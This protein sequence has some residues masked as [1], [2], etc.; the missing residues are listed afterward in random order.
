MGYGAIDG[1]TVTGGL[2]DVTNGNVTS[3]KHGFAPKSPAD[4]AQFLNGAATPA[5]AQV[6]GANLSMSDVTTNNVTSTKHGFA[7]KTPADATQFLNGAATAAYA[8]VKD[9]DLS[10]T[11]ITTNNVSTSKHGFAPKGDGNSAHF[12]DG[13]GA[14]S[15]AS[16]TGNVTTSATLT[17]DAIILGN[18]TTD[19]TVMASLG[20]A[21]NVLASQGP[22]LP[23]QWVAGGGGTGTVTNTGTLTNH[24]LVKGNGG[25]DVSAIGSLGTTT[26]LLHGNASGDP[27]FSAVDLAADVT[28]ALP[29]ANG[30]TGGTAGAWVRLAQIVG[31]GSQATIDFTS[32]SG[33]YSSLK[34]IWW[35]QD[36]ASGTGGANLRMYLHNDTTAAN[37]TVTSRIGAQGS[38][39]FASTVGASTKGVEVG[40]LP[41]AGD[42]GVAGGGEVTLPGYAQTTFHKR[43]GAIAWNDNT[44]GGGI[45]ATLSARWKATTAVDRVTFATDGTAFLD[46]STFTLYGL[47]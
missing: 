11:D 47:P 42:S 29:V 33:S 41:T 4:A 21:G 18:G 24:A 10:T 8:Q 1:T 44:T 15:A 22:G 17:A 31:S 20:S 28:G 27:T 2:S 30:G 43:I 35:A 16:G 19:L 46:G 3:T 7:P 9:S 39:A 14:Y 12:L 32:I 13:T 37:Y 23:P 34:I 6:T 5:F 45:V 36:T 40:F 25:V 26:T 38:S